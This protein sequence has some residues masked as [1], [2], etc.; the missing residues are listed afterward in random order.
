MIR[1]ALWRAIDAKYQDLPIDQLELSTRT[2]HT[3]LR[4]HIY[5]V[6]ELLDWDDQELALING[7][8]PH[9]YAELRQ[10]MTQLP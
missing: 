8:G 10:V 9:S 1:L 7:F 2:R 5:S 4:A 3:L 6:G